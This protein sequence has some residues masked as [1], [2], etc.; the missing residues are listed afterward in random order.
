LKNSTKVTLLVVV[1][2]LIDQALKV[3]VKLN[4][5]LDEEIYLFGWDK[6]RL[7]FVENNGM[8]FGKEL[9][10][11]VGADEWWGKLALSVFRK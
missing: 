6:A 1:I 3:W 5:H 9:S 7:H 11:L 2:L 10:D 4:F 8:A